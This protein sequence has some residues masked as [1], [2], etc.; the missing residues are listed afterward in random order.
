MGR[1]GLWGPAPPHPASPVLPGCAPSFS[2]K[3][4]LEPAGPLAQFGPGWLVAPGA[5]L[6][7]Y[8]SER[9]S[10]SPCWKRERLLSDIY[11]E[12]VAGLLEGK[13]GHDAE[14]PAGIRS[15][16]G[17]SLRRVYVELPAIPQPQ[18]R[19]SVLRWFPRRLLLLGLRSRKPGPP[20]P[21]SVSDREAAVGPVCV[22]LMTQ[23]NWLISQSVQLFIC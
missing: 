21:L 22:P 8:I 19:V 1:E 10:S 17:F 18:L 2:G 16:A 15:P 11:R 13:L 6:V 4:W 23:E 9:P 20:C 7:R 5:G 12:A 14:A 3:G